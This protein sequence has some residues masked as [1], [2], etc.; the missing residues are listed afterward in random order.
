MTVWACC[1]PQT[2]CCPELLHTHPTSASLLMCWSS[3]L[4]SPQE[5]IHQPHPLSHPPSLVLLPSVWLEAATS[6]VCL[7]HRCPLCLMV[8]STDQQ[9]VFHPISSIRGCFFSC[10]LASLFHGRVQ[11][12]LSV[13]FFSFFLFPFCFLCVPGAI[14][15]T[16]LMSS[17]GT[18]RCDSLGFITHEDPAI[19]LKSCIYCVRVL[20]PVM[21]VCGLKKTG[22][23]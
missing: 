13:C 3:L 20:S 18:R 21:R 12:C 4:P 6:A 9:N 22:F 7:C 8:I 16:C 14:H 11:F 17:G 1:M 15:Q 2:L 5:W 23:Q 10:C 19:V